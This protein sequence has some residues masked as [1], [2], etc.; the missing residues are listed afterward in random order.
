MTYDWQAGL[1]FLAILIVATKGLKFL[2]FK[3][4]ALEATRLRNMELWAEKR[5]ME[6]YPPVMR[7]TQKAGMVTNAVFVF[8]VCPFFVTLAPQP[9]W[10]ILLDLAAILM[11][12]DFVYYLTHRFLFH[13]QGYFRKMHAL[14][15]QARDPSYIDAHYVHPLET[16][17]GVFLFVTSIPVMAMWL[18]PFHSVTV[19][20][21][22]LVFTQLNIINHCKIELPYFPFRTLSWITARHAVHHEN[23]H[24]GNYATI[25]L[26]YDKLFRTFS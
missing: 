18:G 19:A 7:A 3:V 2:V 25:T 9:V 6:K 24:K 1:A 5:A 21:A 15:H 20:L 14:H 23:M 12:Y 17:I 26:L 4:P 11:F 22:F 10:K 8:L 16:F 13:G